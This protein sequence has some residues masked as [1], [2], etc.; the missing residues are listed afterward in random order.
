[1]NEFWLIVG[2]T[3]VTFGVRYPPLA[4]VGVLDL[5]PGVQRALR[6]VPVAVLTAIIVPYMLYRE[7]VFTFS[8]TNAY[9][10]GG[11]VAALLSWRTKNLLLTIGVGLVFFF[12]YRV[13]LG[14]L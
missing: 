5:P 1:M 13:L 14:A 10:V 7:D 2:M 6:Y 9:L 8:H 4:L 3:A 12:A 11:V